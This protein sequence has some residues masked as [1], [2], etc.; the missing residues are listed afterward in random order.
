M[1]GSK[2][3]VASRFRENFK[4]IIILK[5]ICH[6]LHL[7]A[8]EACKNLPRTPEDLARNIYNFF[9]ASAKRLAEYQQFQIFA[10]T[11]VHKLL[12]PSQTRWLSLLNVVCKILEQWDALRL[13]FTHKYISER[14]LAAEQIYRS[15]EDPLIKTY[16]MF[17]EWILPKFTNL[18]LYFQKG[19]PLILELHSRT[20]EGYKELLMC[21][22]NDRYVLQNDLMSIDPQNRTQFKKKNELYL[23]VK[24]LQLISEMK[25]NIVALDHFYD[26]C[27]NFFSTF[28]KQIRERYDF[29]DHLLSQLHQF[30][31][32]N[33]TTTHRLE[34]LVPLLKLT[35]LAA[36]ENWQHIDDEWRKLPLF[37]K[38]ELPS[39]DSEPDIFWGKLKKINTDGVFLFRNVS[40]YVLNILSLP[41]SNAECERVF[42]K[43]NLIKT[44]LRNTLKIDTIGKSILASQFVSGEGGAFKLNPL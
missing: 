40:E 42:S 8:S 16:F 9:K 31:P 41:H 27:L 37:P 17:L 36:F 14:L 5:C 28:C 3:S 6:P 39:V 18:N 10:N 29:D 1:M 20:R 25:S 22:M 32:K 34:S 23:G 44:K 33:A 13:Y 43:L 15:L 24:V 7:C 19:S 2:N 21:Y 11:D 38:N 12:H 26:C 35:R 30:K 4:G